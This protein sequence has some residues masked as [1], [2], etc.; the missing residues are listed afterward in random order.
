MDKRRK[1]ISKDDKNLSD[2]I[3]D[4]NPQVKSDRTGNATAAR[5][6]QKTND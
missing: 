2:I 6:Y 5:G 3:A 1:A 4:N